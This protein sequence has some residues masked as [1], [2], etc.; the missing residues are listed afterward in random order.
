MASAVLIV[1]IIN[2]PQRSGSAGGTTAQLER[3]EYSVM[4]IPHAKFSASA[5]TGGVGEMPPGRS[6]R[7]CLF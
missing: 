5:E 2:Q 4:R 3:A 7:W 6:D 1:L